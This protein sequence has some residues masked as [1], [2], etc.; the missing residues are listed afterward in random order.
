MEDIAKK[1]FHGNI[2]DKERAIFELG[3]ALGFVYHQFMAMPFKTKDI[4]VIKKAIEASIL[5]QPY[6][7]SAKIQIVDKNQEINPYSYNEINK[8]NIK[9]E[10]KVK[11]GNYVVTGKLEYIEEINYPLMYISNIEEINHL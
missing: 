11:Y 7:V 5:A 8:R 2:N 10:I 6:R 9:A 1:Y 4:E 3:I